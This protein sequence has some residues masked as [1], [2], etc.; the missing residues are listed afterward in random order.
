MKIEL[1]DDFE[2]IY[3]RLWSVRFNFAAGIFA[4]LEIILPLFE[5]AI[6]RGLFAGISVVA[7]V[8]SAVARGIAQKALYAKS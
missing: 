1:I 3:H 4:G 7:T 6:P 2:R 8:C 5:S